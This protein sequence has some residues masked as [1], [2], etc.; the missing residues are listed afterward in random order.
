MN[1]T[2]HTYRTA[3]ALLT[4]ATLAAA[5]LALAACNVTVVGSNGDTNPGAG[6]HSAADL[7]CASGQL[8]SFVP[9]RYPAGPLAT[10]A[11]YLY[12]VELS[13]ASHA[14][15]E[16]GQYTHELLRTSKA[17]GST[18]VIESGLGDVWGLTLDG[19]QLYYALLLGGSPLASELRVL[20][21]DG[22]GPATALYLAETAFTFVAA[23]PDRIFLLLWQQQAQ[24]NTELVSVNKAD[25]TAT[26][27]APQAALS[28]WGVLA[29][30]ATH[31]Y[32]WDDGASRIASL[33]K[34]GGVPQTFALVTEQSAWVQQ[35]IAD[36]EDV[37]WVVT[38]P[39]A[40]ATFY[41]AP[42]AGGA[43]PA[44]ARVALSGPNA[45]VGGMALDDSCLYWTE[46]TSDSNPQTGAHLGQ[47]HALRKSDGTLALPTP[48]E[49]APG[50]VIADESG[51]FLVAP[52][53]TMSP[54]PYSDPPGIKGAVQRIAR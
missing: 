33:A 20:P 9:E 31:L 43:P 15:F 13:Y 48:A 2:H 38:A 18:T 27:L 42:K 41:R 30:D 24:P 29:E 12:W 3:A 49:P 35:V 25:G 26:V 23:D 37:Y 36:G 16:A 52:A 7:G 46:T 10:D 6:G 32:W 21:K 50:P 28:S 44:L 17:D 5:T 1:L 39:D 4:A 47:V 22:S 45:T 8:E 40:H 14:D 54:P 34:A 11:Q 19:D 51:V 53:A